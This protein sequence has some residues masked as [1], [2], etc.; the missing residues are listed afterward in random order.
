MTERK[1]AVNEVSLAI[2][3]GALNKETFFKTL[4][5]RLTAVLP[6]QGRERTA[7]GFTL[8]ELLVVVL[9]IGI[10][11]AIALP[12]YKLAVEKSRYA[13]LKH[14]AEA[15][16]QAQE[17][18]YLA[19][20]KYADTLSELD[21]DFP[22]G[23]KV[24]ADDNKIT[25]NWGNCRIEAENAQCRNTQQTEAL[26]YQFQYKNTTGSAAGKKTCMVVHAEGLTSIRQRI[27]RQETGKT[28]ADYI[29]NTLKAYSYHYL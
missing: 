19:N 16:G 5:P 28:E 15:V 11:A 4:L 24:N 7:R 26:V 22:S 21:V 29:N 6:P 13:T 17:V 25:Y 8:I 27:C 10:L 9:I 12:Q 14:L 20:G 1:N 2:K 18:Y 23:G 3:R